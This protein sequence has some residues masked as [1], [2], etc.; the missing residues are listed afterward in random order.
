[1]KSSVSWPGAPMALASAALFGA[2]TPLA[3]LLLGGG[4]DPGRR[5]V[6][7][8]WQGGPAGVGL[9]EADKACIG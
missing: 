4:V 3:K 9:V 8:S 1:M 2:S 7:L 5:A 6:L